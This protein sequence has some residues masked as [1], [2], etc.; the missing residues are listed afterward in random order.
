VTEPAENER[1]DLSALSCPAE[2]IDAIGERRT[3][4]IYNHGFG[5]NLDWWNERIDQLGLPGGPIIGTRDG[6]TVSDGKARIERRDLFG[7]AD[8]ARA[9]PDGALAL[10]WHALAWGSGNK[11]RNNG[12]RL[13]AVAADVGSASEGMRLAA[14]RSQEDAKAAFFVCC[15][16]PGQNI[17][18]YLGPSFATKFLY[19]SGGGRP[20]HPCL[21]LDERVAKTLRD[22]AG[23]W[24]LD[25]GNFWPAQTYERYCSL[26]HRWSAETSRSSRPV[27]ADELERALFELAG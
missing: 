15:P 27:C 2:V 25:P 4:A 7:L 19:F 20:E 23:W 14:E 17:I 11:L 10:L 18:K 13:Q 24:S 8:E 1:T 5:I 22:Q 6:E 3:E 21:I 16:V 9:T 12:L 26:L